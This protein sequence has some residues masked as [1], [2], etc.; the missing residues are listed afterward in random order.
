MRRL[1]GA[2]P[3]LVGVVECARAASQSGIALRR[4]LRFILFG[5]EEAKMAGSQH[6]VESLGDAALLSFI[7]NLEMIGYT[8]ETDPLDALARQSRGDWIGAYAPDWA[9]DCPADFARAAKLFVPG[10]KFYATAIPATYEISP[11]IDNIA[12][13]DHIRFWRRG[14]PGLMV[15][16]GAEIRNPN[17]HGPGDTL[18]TLDLP[19]MTRV[20]S[21]SL[22]VALLRAEPM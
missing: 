21:A 11:L 3:G 17:Y 18:S 14:V 4:G 1:P 15:T 5:M 6:Y 2:V 19:F 20:V 8:A 9:A 16:D 7:V 13:S 10:L 22:A 12:R